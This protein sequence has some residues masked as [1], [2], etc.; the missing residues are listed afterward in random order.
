MPKLL[1]A[2][3][4]SLLLL[5]LLMITAPGMA[6]CRSESEI[7]STTPTADFT[8]H[9]D[10]T[11][12]HQSTGLMWMKCPLGQSGVD[13]ATGIS[14]TYT[15]EGALQAADATTYAGYSDWRL[16]NKNELSS[17]LERRCSGPAIN[18]TVFPGIPHSYSFY[19]WSSSPYAHGSGNAWL[20][21]FGDGGNYRAY[22]YDSRHVRLVRSGQ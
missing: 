9:G 16:P 11:V 19:F 13:C 17:I 6:A 5:L 14:H 4:R 21:D 12:T 7:P 2:T 8:D 1:K 3:P 18:A 10:G 20:V 15:W 22:R